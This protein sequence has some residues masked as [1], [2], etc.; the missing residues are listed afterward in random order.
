MSFPHIT[1]FITRFSYKYVVNSYFKQRNEN[2]RKT[3]ELKNHH[4]MTDD[5][6]GRKHP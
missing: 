1:N 3:D 6:P 4:S 2:K 5:I